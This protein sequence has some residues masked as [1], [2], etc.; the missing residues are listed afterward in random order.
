MTSQCNHN[1]VHALTTYSTHPK[2]GTVITNKL[3]Q[4]ATPKVR[5]PVIIAVHIHVN[6][7]HVSNKQLTTNNSASDQII[8]P[9][10]SIQ[11]QKGPKQVTLSPSINKTKYTPSKSP[12][13]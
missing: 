13:K 9:H 3:S 1:R 11:Q 6:K 4:K 2:F 12:K 8:R 5:R 7:I 10:P